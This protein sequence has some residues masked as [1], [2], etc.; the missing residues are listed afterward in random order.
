MEAQCIEDTSDNNIIIT[1][2]II[3][4]RFLVQN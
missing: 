3:G 4:L 1:I 2:M